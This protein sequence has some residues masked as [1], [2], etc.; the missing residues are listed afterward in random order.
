MRCRRESGP[1]AHVRWAEG[2]L[3]AL[4]ML[5]LASRLLEAERSAPLPAAEGLV[6]RV[7]LNRAPWHEL[8]NLPGIGEVRAREIVRDRE[9]RGPFRDL[10]DL[11]RVRGVGEVTIA[12]LERHVS[13]G[14]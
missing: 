2:L 9:R 12:V 10:R 14:R 13:G 4:V 8:T 1:G 5:L 6:H 11:A 3:I 7:D